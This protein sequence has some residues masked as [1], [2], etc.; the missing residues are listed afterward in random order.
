MLETTEETTEETMVD[1]VE[2]VDMVV[3]MMDTVVETMVVEKIVDMVVQSF[4]DM[5][6]ESFEG[7]ILVVVVVVESLIVVVETVATVGIV[8]ANLVGKMVLGSSFANKM[9]RMDLKTVE[10]SAK[11]QAWLME[12][13]LAYHTVVV[14]NFEMI[15]R[16]VEYMANHI[17]HHIVLEM[18]SLILVHT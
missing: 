5:E 8:T 9:M 1:T 6:A 10:H 16:T 4:V 7:E 2:I 12:E 18:D 17:R 14:H 13:K 11:Q 3:E 15:E